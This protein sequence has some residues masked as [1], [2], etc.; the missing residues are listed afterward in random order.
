M[1]KKTFHIFSRVTLSLLVLLTG[2]SVLAQTVTPLISPTPKVG[3]LFDFITTILGIV[4]KIAIPALTVYIIYSGFT[5]ATAGGDEAKY[6]NAKTMLIWG[7]I[8]AAIILG[9]VVIAR[10]LQGTVTA[11]S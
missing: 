6:K 1:K 3:S 2:L 4:I 9:A 8:G 11:I 7:F 10:A 5:L